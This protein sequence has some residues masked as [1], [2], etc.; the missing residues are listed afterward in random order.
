GRCFDTD[1]EPVIMG[2]VNLSPDSTYRESIAPTPASAIRKGRIQAAQGAHL[3]DLGAES[4]G[5]RASLVSPAE[6]VAA[7]VPVVEVLA[8]ESIPTSVEAY[9]PVVVQAALFAGA[10]VVNLTGSEHDDQ[11]FALVAE[12]KASL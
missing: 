1:R 11:N 3:I 8:A 7:I 10:S 12:H 2:T 4:S 9:D 5:A 6:Q